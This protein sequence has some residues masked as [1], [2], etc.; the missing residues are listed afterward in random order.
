[1]ICYNYST[2]IIIL[3]N[4]LEAILSKN[5]DIIMCNSIAVITVTILLVVDFTMNY[6]II[7]IITS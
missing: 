1:M 5:S 7:T 4:Y 2:Y 3:H 6:K